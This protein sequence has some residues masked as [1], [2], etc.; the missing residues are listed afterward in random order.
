M[1][2]NELYVNDVKYKWSTTVN[3]CRLAQFYLELSHSM[4]GS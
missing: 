2:E 4:I 1:N 3:K